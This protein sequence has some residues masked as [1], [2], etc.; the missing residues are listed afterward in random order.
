MLNINERFKVTPMHDTILTIYS[1][2]NDTYLCW[3]AF[4]KYYYFGQKDDENI[5][6]WSS[7]K[8]LNNFYVAAIKNLSVMRTPNLCPR[9]ATLIRNKN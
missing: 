4:D 2:T 8:A 5:I 3:D 9:C 6:F 1:D 7:P